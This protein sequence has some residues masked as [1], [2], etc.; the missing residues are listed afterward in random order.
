VTPS[1][2]QDFKH[3][4]QNYVDIIQGNEWSSVFI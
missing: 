3:N 2:T 4:W 1:H